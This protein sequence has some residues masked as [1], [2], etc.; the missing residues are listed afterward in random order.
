[1]TSL[2]SIRAALERQLV[3]NVNWFLGTGVWREGGVWSDGQ[4]WTTGAS[5]VTP[6][7]PAIASPNVPFTPVEG[8]PYLRVQFAPVLRRPVVAGPDP[9]QRY[10]GLF[11]V[12]IFTPED[13]GAGA[14]MAIA[15]QLLD[16]YTGSDALLTQDAVVRL[17]YSEAKMP[18]HEPPFFAI[19]L[20]IGWYAYRS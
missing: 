14:G 8:T 12:T 5:I 19:P 9:E 16:R 18:L 2:N 6:A 3:E 13:L 11:F 20:E 17:E 4:S 1:M 7:L 10:S 15:D